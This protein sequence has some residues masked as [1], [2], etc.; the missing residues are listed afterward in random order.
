VS[1]TFFGQLVA[2]NVILERRLTFS[3]FVRLHPR[4]REVFDQQE[5]PG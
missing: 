1:D 3:A 4:V 5:W 2:R